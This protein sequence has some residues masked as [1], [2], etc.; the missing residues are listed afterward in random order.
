MNKELRIGMIGL[1]TSHCGLFTRVFNDSSYEYHIPGSRV[2]VAYPGGSSDLPSSYSR[3][4]E[5]TEELRTKFGV[6]MVDTIEEVAE[7]TDAILLT[8]LDG[9]VH[10]EQFRRI[11][12]YG[13]PVYINKPFALSVRDAETL[14]ELADKHHVALMSCSSLRYAKELTQS[15]LQDERGQIMGADAYSPMP[16]EA[17]NPGWFWY[18]IHAVEMLYTAL[19]KGCRAIR[20]YSNGN[21]ESVVGVW[22]DGRIGTVR[23]NR[24]NNHDYGIAVHRE[25]GT[26]T[27]NPL[28]GKRPFYHPLLVEL[29]NMFKTGKSPLDPTITLEITRFME[30][31]N[32]SRISGAEVNIS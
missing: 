17:N 12:A 8:S 30:A 7:R 29:M 19:P 25:S 9:R 26:L 5:Y 14:F 31:A 18:G 15:L 32:E 27:I 23:G 4:G 6:A 3:V 1:D 22:E 24:M 10:V 28:A 20:S 2:T 11:A 21:S 13:K 16:L